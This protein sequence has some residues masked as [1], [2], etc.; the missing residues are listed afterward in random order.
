[1]VALIGLP[2]GVGTAVAAGGGGV[3]A[4][5]REEHLVKGRLAQRRVLWRDAGRL[6]A[7]QRHGQSPWAVR[8]REDHPG[9]ALV[10][11][12][13]WLT[14]VPQCL[15]HPTTVGGCDPQLDHRAADAVLELGSGAL[16]HEPAVVDDR[17]PVGELV[18]LLQVLG[19]Q[20]HR[21]ARVDQVADQRPQVVAAGGVQAGGGLV[22]EQHPGAAD[23][24]GG[25]VQAAAHPPGVGLDLPVG[26][27]Y[28]VN[29]LEDFAGAPSRWTASQPIEPADHLDVLPAGEVVVNGGGLARQADPGAHARRVGAHVDAGDAGGAR[30][31]CQQG[32]ED[33]DESGLAGAVGAQQGMDGPGPH[34]QAQLV[35]RTDLAAVGL[36]QPL[37]LDDGVVHKRAP[38]LVYS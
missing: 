34:G 33:P 3:V 14:A 26:H 7:A 5:Q 25:Q 1:V 10:E 2:P 9:V 18:G 6:Q 36:D 8:R 21:R 38:Q 32:G 16:T 20:Q 27:V 24:G 29:A 17:D 35:Q 12:R 37:G 13:G 22:Q 30:V 11:G 28:Q 4:G 23:Q 19:G 15:Q 31:R